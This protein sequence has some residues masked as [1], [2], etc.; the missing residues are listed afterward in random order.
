MSLEAVTIMNSTTVTPPQSAVSIA[1][2]IEKQ[3][4]YKTQVEYKLRPEIEALQAQRRHTIEMNE[5][6]IE[7][8]QVTIHVSPVGSGRFD[9]D[10]ATLS[11]PVAVIDAGGD[12]VKDFMSTAATK[13]L[14]D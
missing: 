6:Y 11:V 2:L 14:L 8:E 3:F 13:P 9:F 7:G 5:Y 4:A 1:T 10:V 12:T